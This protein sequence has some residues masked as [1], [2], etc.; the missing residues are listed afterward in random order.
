MGQRLR[1]GE[2]A[3]QVNLEIDGGENRA[4]KV[5]PY[6]GVDAQGIPT[7]GLSP[8]TFV[9]TVSLL[10]LAYALVILYLL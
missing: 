3:A 10:S 9:S 4:G 8:C 1:V 5:R 6:P 7:A 2:E